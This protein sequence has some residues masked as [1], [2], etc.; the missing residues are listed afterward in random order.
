[1]RKKFL[2]PLT[3]IGAAAIGFF[4]FLP[5]YVEGSMNAVDG[6]PLIK[7]SDEAK[8]L[9][10]TLNI[11]DLHSDTLMWNRDLGDRAD[12]GHMDLPRLQEGNVA[13]QLFSSVT[14][15]P[16]GQN[17]DGNGADT[18]NITLLTFAQLQPVKTWR[19]L[20]ERSLYH[21]S[22]RDHAV[23]GSD[24]KLQAVDKA[25]QLDALLAARQKD[26]STVGAMLTIEGLHNL[27]GKAE[28]LDRL[29]DAGFRMAGFTHF[30][31][32]ELGGSMHGLKKGGLTPFGRDILRR[33][34]A[35]GMIVDIAHLSH[36]G[37]AEVLAMAKRP[38]VSSHGGVQATCKVNRNL[39][40][41]EVRG[42]AKTGGIIGIG[43]WE[44]AICSTDPRAAAKA[45]KH[46]RD[47]VGIQ[48]VALG[49]DYDG[50][51]TVRFDTSQLAQVTQAL[52][53][54]GFTPDEIRAVMGENALRVIRA[55]LVPMANVAQ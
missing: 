35:K 19:S 33:M 52:M 32:N 49:S 20:V 23:S 41:D 55:G 38:V 29:Y 45:M 44:G 17:Y 53:D 46:V 12:R 34:E 28:N 9:H 5:G 16:K 25:Q 42:V 3:L 1:M 47:L 54:E 18:D 51:T 36:A 37:V 43:Y 40:D 26:R 11:V 15:T 14:K 4:G 48:H 2:I 30:F 7:V 50:A 21:A 39:T 22:K 8:V 6:Q 13:L 24:G 10:K 31:D 27:E